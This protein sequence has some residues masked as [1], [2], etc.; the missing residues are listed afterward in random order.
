MKNGVDVAFDLECH[1]H[2]TDNQLERSVV[3]ERLEV[4]KASR[5]K[6]VDTNDAVTAR[7]ERLAQ[8]GT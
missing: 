1:A 5:G 8:M 4:R 2:V 7:H 3:L 6:I